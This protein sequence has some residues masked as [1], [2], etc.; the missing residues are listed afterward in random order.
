M[1]A[2]QP[3][4]LFTAMFVGFWATSAYFDHFLLTTVFCIAFG[5][6]AEIV[7]KSLFSG[8]AEGGS[9]LA[10]KKAELALLE[11]LA[12]RERRE[13]EERERRDMEDR[14]RRELAMANSE[15]VW[16]KAEHQEDEAEDE[17]EDDGPP[18][19]P[20]RDYEAPAL[21]PMVTLLDPV[22]ETMDR[23]IYLE[24]QR[25]PTLDD[26]GE[27]MYERSTSDEYN[28]NTS[29][30]DLNTRAELEEEVE[31]IYMDEVEEGYKAEVAYGNDNW[32]NNLVD[33]EDPSRRSDSNQAGETLASQGDLMSAEVQRALI[34]G[35]SS[36][37]E[38]VE[39]VE[40]EDNLYAPDSSDDG[41]LD[42][43]F[44]NRDVNFE[45]SEEEEEGDGQE[46]DYMRKQEEKLVSLEDGALSSPSDGEE[47]VEELVDRKGVIINTEV[48][49]TDTRTSCD[50]VIDIDLTDPEVQAAATKIQSAFKGFRSRK[51][52]KT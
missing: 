51:L 6:V 26:R 34:N 35:V 31:E 1:G 37:D 50:P 29:I 20:T 32:K 22:E 2:M 27:R 5:V 7:T 10:R 36:S 40:L 28:Q 33:V 42:E 45:D 17:D 21:P 16:R 49:D 52:N 18:P 25:I 24:E 23:S 39:E 15:A 11:E 30:R 47:R 4:Q 46:F 12:D 43:E 3:W 14:E 44:I 13:M 41:E 38:E 48:T 8:E 9:E 19:L